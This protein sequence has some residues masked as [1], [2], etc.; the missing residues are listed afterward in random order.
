MVRE[1]VN[2]TAS[3][4]AP[5]RYLTLAAARALECNGCGDCCDSRRTDGWTWAALP[6]DGYRSL[7]GGR[8]LIIP[9]EL[10]DADWRDRE[11]RPEDSAEFSGTRFR[12]AALQT[13]PDG[14][15]SCLRHDQPR[16][17]QCGRFPVWGRAIEAE[18]RE[19][20]E[21]RLQTGSLPRC[22]WHRLVVLEDG[23]PRLD[24]V[25]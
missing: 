10:V 11:Q 4:G 3:Q 13:H 20:H 25:E 6:E 23:D 1:T 22:T 12:C 2:P 17:E 15:A 5:L 7:T 9:I 21:V 16:P 8:P 14:T 19:Q 24:G 18:L